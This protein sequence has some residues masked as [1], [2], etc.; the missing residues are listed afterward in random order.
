MNTGHPFAQLT[1]DFVLSAVESR[2]YLCDGRMLTLNSYEN[3]VY[4]IGMEGT[5]P[6]IA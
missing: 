1:P 3:R 5:D 4:Q 6:L 2:S